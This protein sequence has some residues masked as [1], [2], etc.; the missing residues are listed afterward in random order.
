MINIPDRLPANQ[1]VLIVS[2]SASR[3]ISAVPFS[4]STE[5][6][7]PHS[8]SQSVDIRERLRRRFSLRLVLDFCFN[9]TAWS[10]PSATKSQL[11]CPLLSV[12]SP[13]PLAVL[14]SNMTDFQRWGGDLS[15]SRTRPQVIQIASCFSPSKVCSR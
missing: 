7:S 13:A 1:F 6:S 15:M 9:R 5:I 12:G 3:I 11:A 14:P 10:A 8:P 2:Q 4:K